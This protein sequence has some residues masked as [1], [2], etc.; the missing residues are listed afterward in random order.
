MMMTTVYLVFGLALTAMCINI[1]QVSER[2]RESER[3]GRSGRSVGWRE[4]ERRNDG[5]EQGYGEV[6][7]VRRER[8]RER[9]RRGVLRRRERD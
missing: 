4:S 3:M 1:I 2:E 9:G 6:C 8:E 5:R 7:W